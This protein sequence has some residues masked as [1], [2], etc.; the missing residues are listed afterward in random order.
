MTTI[1]GFQGRIYCEKI[2]IFQDRRNAYFK[3]INSA[4]VLL[5]CNKEFTNKIENR[6]C[7]KKLK[8]NVNSNTLSLF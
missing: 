6:C 4:S 1:L 8:N 3:S 2:V 7:G 5:L